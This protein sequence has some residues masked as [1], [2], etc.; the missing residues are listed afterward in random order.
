MSWLAIAVL[1]SIESLSYQM[2]ISGKYQ[3]KVQS[4]L[5]VTLGDHLRTPTIVAPGCSRGPAITR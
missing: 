3:A 1:C 4:A 5:P 2:S